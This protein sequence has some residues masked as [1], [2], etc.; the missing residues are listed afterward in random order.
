[1]QKVTYIS[2]SGDGHHTDFDRLFEAAAQDIGISIDKVSAASQTFDKRLPLFYS[3]FDRKPSQTFSALLSAALRSLCGRK[4]VGLFF[5]PGYCFVQGSIKYWVRRYL[6]AIVSRLPHVQILSIV[7]FPLSPRF[8]LVASNWIYDPQ[9][10]DTR[11]LGHSHLDNSGMI[12][13]T[14]SE[15]AN[16]R[17]IIVALGGQ[18]K[19]KG[20]DYFTELWCSSPGI[21]E[22]FLFVAAGKVSDSSKRCAEKFE[23]NEGLLIN[24][25]IEDAEL[26]YLYDKAHAVWSC[27]APDYDQSSGIHGRAVQFGI[28]V[29]VRAG[30]LIES[31]GALLPHPTLALSFDD[32]ASAARMLLGWHPVRVNHATQEVLI[33]KMREHSIA[34][35]ANAFGGLQKI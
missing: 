30:S 24:R 14:L 17:Q 11:Y 13:K 10:W 26:F 31:L 35:L 5:R 9:L 32:E 16:G 4:T 19:T 3:M 21:R 1:M 20:F 18:N 25:R 33:C 15:K 8:A 28:P 6:F 27:Y 34:V 29:I 7:P 23:Q 12:E 2:D 22:K